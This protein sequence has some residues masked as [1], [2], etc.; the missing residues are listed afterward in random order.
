[1][2]S[3]SPPPSAALEHPLIG[4][5]FLLCSH[6]G[7]AGVFFRREDCILASEKLAAVYGEDKSSVFLSNTMPYYAESVGQLLQYLEGFRRTFR[8]PLDLSLTTSRYQRKVLMEVMKVPYGAATTY[9][10]IAKTVGGSARAVGGANAKN[11]L[12]IIIPCHRVLGQN[13]R[14]C[15]YS[16][17]LHIKEALLR[18]EAHYLL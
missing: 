4:Q 7:A 13:R 17:G 1:M 11:P 10:E 14:L 9:G 6:R 3:D 15:G 18:L 16:G 5:L 8:L 2:D 12:A